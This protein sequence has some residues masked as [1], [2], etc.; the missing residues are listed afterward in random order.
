MNYSI[1]KTT[2]FSLLWEERQKSQRFLA[3]HP[4]FLKYRGVRIYSFMPFSNY[5]ELSQQLHDSTTPSIH[6]SIIHRIG[7]DRIKATY[8]WSA[9][10][11]VDEVLVHFAAAWWDPVALRHEALT[12]VTWRERLTPPFL[13]LVMWFFGVCFLVEAGRLTTSSWIPK[14]WGE[15]FFFGKWRA[16]ITVIKNHHI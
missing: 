15:F 8:R 10:R 6:P 3:P 2:W 9:A 14:N 13:R 16:L 1:E 5:K 11:R 7:S 12:H 4:P